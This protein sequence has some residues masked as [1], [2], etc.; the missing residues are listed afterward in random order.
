MAMNFYDRIKAINGASKK[1]TAKEVMVA[2][3]RNDFSAH[4]MD[5]ID[6]QSDT[7]VNGM[8]QRLIVSCNKN[9]VTEKLFWTYPGENVYLGDVV[10]C[11]N[12]KWLITEIDP[13]DDICV[14]GKME[15]CNREIS[16]QNPHTLEIISR[17]VTMSRPYYSNLEEN[18]QTTISKRMYKIQ[19]PYDNET[20]LFDNGK[21]FMLEIID[22][23]PKTYRITSVDISTK[24][25]QM[26]GTIQGFIVL[27]VEQDQYNELTDNSELMICDYIDP[28]T[29]SNPD[30]SIEC[31]IQ[32]IGD[33]EL[34]IGGQPKKF[35]ALF[36]DNHG[37]IINND[38]VWEA[39]YLD[40][41][42][43]Y[44]K[45]EQIGADFFITILS[46]AN[47]LEGSYINIILKDKSGIYSDELL[48]KVVAL[49]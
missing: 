41:F 49:I 2:N 14:K 3:L 40:E 28:N 11:F 30:T 15:Q 46:G 1:H 32:Y 10:D 39:N 47:L 33:P 25:Y 16:W 35:S 48:C 36:T 5:T 23:N 31:K 45:T 22:G 21:R 38:P 29:N 12:C 19:I 34:K 42:K 9:V 44:I 24:R 13:N 8:P 7:L 26:H 4:F 6:Y 37:N 43:D 18:Q 20:A 17:W 27:Q